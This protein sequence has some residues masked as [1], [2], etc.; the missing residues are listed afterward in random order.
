MTQSSKHD[1]FGEARCDCG[2][3]LF[4]QTKRGFEFKCNRCKRIH[5][6]PFDSIGKE[7]QHLCP[8]DKSVD[9]VEN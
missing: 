4:K 1:N 8:I 5:L 2:R 9:E 7:F 6:V 3:L